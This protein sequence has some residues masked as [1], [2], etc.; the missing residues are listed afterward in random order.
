MIKPVPVITIDGPSGSGKGTVAALLAGKLGWNFLDSGALYRLLAFAAR[1]HG[2]DLTNEE[3]LKVLAEHLD[4]QFGAA[5]DGHG[6]VIILEGE[7]VT[8]AIRNETV[9]AGASQVAALPVV[10]AALLQRQKAFREAP[11]LVADGRDMG[12]VVFPDAPLKIFLTASAEER[13]RRRYLQLKARGDDVNLASLLGE[14]RERDERDTQRAVAP[15][16]PAEDAIQL[17]STTLSIEEVL[18]RILSEV[19]DRDLAG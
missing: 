9:G 4:V 14:I 6:M 1:N 11:G 17:D 18:Q 5:R 8:E 19:A 7:D 15:L 13:A 2:V 12:T 16:K 3:A 10:R